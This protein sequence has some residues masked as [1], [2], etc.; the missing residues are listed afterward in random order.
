MGGNGK[1]VK[2]SCFE[3]NLK[4]S[5]LGY[6]LNS[7]KRDVIKIQNVITGFSLLTVNS[8]EFL[9]N[10]ISLAKALFK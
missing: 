10:N 6:Q 7:E 4:N 3:S 9:I 2:S 5:V 1:I 8:D